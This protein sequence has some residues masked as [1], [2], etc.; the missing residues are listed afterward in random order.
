MSAMITARLYSF[1]IGKIYAAPANRE[2]APSLIEIVGA[3]LNFF[4]LQ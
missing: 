4:Q 3:L 2:Q 1:R